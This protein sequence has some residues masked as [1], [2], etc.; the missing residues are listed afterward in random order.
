MKILFV[1]NAAMNRS[2]TGVDVVKENFPKDE[3][4]FAGTDELADI[5]ITTGAIKWADIIFVMENHHLSYL[6]NY[7]PDETKNKKI[8][9]LGIPDIFKRDDPNL[10]DMILAGIKPYLKDTEK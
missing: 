6:L 10:K 2:P 7:F 3:A 9:S 5:R 4:K 1:C 8:I